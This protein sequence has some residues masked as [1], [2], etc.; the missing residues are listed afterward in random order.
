[1]RILVILRRV[2]DPA[3]IVAHRRLR[4]LFINREEYIIQP[5]DHCAL[6]AA[7][8]IKDR[9]GAEVMVVSGQPEPD[10]DTVRRGLAMGADRA[11]YLAGDGFGE[12]DEAAM[13]RV[14]EAVIGQVGGVDLVLAGLTTLDT[15]QGQL[16]PRLAEALGWP[17]ILGAWS[18]E[19]D[20][21]RLEAVRRDG[22]RY[23]RVETELPAVVTVPEGA[24]PPR[25]P[26]GAR[27]IN[28]YRGEG[29]M[30]E[31]LEQWDAAGLVSPDAL[32]PV[33]EGRGRDFPPE[34]ERGGRV[35]GTA[36]E[37]GQAVAEA[38]RSRLGL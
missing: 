17:Q 1:M 32:V 34:R 23:V 19:A 35:E 13:T 7:L 29:G 8:R 27:L 5:G 14:L 20:D 38:L 10:N 3:G 4:Q 11:I 21:G 24:F 15:G 26:D 22:D 2:L 12:A 31:A 25:Y 16:G 36:Q 9:T 33:L 28:V 18:V 30:E 37:A 6:E